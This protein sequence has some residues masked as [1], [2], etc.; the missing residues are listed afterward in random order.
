MIWAYDPDI[1]AIPFDPIKAKETLASKGYTDSDGDGWLDK[2]G[3][4]F[5][6][7]VLTNQGNQIRA[8][9]AVMVQAMLADIGVKVEPVLLEWTYFLERYK[10]REFDAV[11]QAWRTSTKA[12]LAPIWSCEAAGPTGYN[13]VNYCN[14][15]VDSL[16]SV[17]TSLFD[18]SEAT[19]PFFKAQAIIYSEQPYTFLYISPALCAV[20][21]TFDGIEPTAISFYHNLYEWK[22]RN[23]E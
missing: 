4:I 17:A 20:R 3:E 16:N 7:E 12:D 22:H 6:F 2:D 21:S 19:A 13:R 23:D 11:I 10:A 18:P 9:I 14:H 8:D 1:E 5:K 15:T